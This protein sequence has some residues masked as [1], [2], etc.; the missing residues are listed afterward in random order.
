[1]TRTLNSRILGFFGSIF[2]DH[3][4]ELVTKI[5]DDVGSDNELDNGHDAVLE[6]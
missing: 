3:T 2:A 1:M 5:L 6:F 4:M